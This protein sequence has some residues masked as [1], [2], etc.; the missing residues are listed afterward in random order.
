MDGE[1]PLDYRNL[2]LGSRLPLNY[3]FPGKL[4]KDGPYLRLGCRILPDGPVQ[5]GSV[6][7]NPVKNL[8][9][10]G[11]SRVQVRQKAIDWTYTLNFC[12]FT[13]KNWIP[14]W[15]SGCPTSIRILVLVRRQLK[16]SDCPKWR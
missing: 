11:Q 3:P 7:G 14:C 1:L 13:R 16:Y 9:K 6:A 4:D 8:K 5:L 10:S 2:W 12:I 15:F